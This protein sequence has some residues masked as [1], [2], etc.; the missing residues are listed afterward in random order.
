VKQSNEWNKMS[1]P[2]FGERA[3]LFGQGSHFD[4]ELLFFNG[5]VNP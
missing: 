3:T 2:G 4:D 5:A 1:Q